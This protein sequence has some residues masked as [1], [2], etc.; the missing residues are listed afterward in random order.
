MGLFSKKTKY[1]L[2]S[3]NKKVGSLVIN[4]KLI[5]IVGVDEEDI[6]PFIKQFCRLYH[7]NDY[8]IEIKLH[9]IEKRIIALTFPNDIDFVIF[10]YL[11]KHLN[12]ASTIQ[13]LIKVLGWCTLLPIEPTNPISKQAM[14]YVDENNVSEKTVSITTQDNVCWKI[15][16]NKNE[17]IPSSLLQQFSK[18][19]YSFLEIKH[20]KGYI[21]G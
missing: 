13:S 17:Y 10:F 15:D 6:K 19:P 9:P 16:F 4:D 18:P 14:V 21:I 12:C 11:V 5:V 8:S 20:S 1:P 2:P 3:V 7:R